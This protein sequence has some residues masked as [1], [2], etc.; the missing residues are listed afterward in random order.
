MSV[1]TYGHYESLRHFQWQ[2]AFS[3]RPT[4]EVGDARLGSGRLWGKP[5][6]PCRTGAAKRSRYEGSFG[7]AREGVPLLRGRKCGRVW[8]CR[9]QSCHHGER[10]LSDWGFAAGRELRAGVLALGA[11]HFVSWARYCRY[12]VVTWGSFGWYFMFHEWRTYNDV[13]IYFVPCLVHYSEWGVSPDPVTWHQLGQTAWELRIWGWRGWESWG[14]PADMG[15]TCV[16]EGMLDDSGFVQ[17][18]PSA[19][20]YH[21][22]SRSRCPCPQFVRGG[23][24]QWLKCL[25]RRSRQL[26]GQWVP[27][28]TDRLSSLRSQSVEAMP[29]ADILKCFREFERLLHDG[30]HC[31][32]AEGCRNS[33]LDAI[34][35]CPQKSPPHERP[36]YA[37]L[38]RHCGKHH[39]CVAVN[40]LIT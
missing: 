7:R 3:P 25:G 35:P 5:T 40:R 28:K 2:Q 24:Q 8:C 31:Q 15:E 26:F 17:C 16:P 32:S 18:W 27:A 37:A 36:E 10:V 33:R 4:F 11:V 20:S 29:A 34:S 1:L 38:S 39:W 12:D 9:P 14:L 21:F 6:E 13:C 22:G 19:W 30:V 23:A